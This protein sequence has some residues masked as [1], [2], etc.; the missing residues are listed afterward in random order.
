MFAEHLAHQS[1]D[2]EVECIVG[3]PGNMIK[4]IRSGDHHHNISV[5]YI[6]FNINCPFSIFLPILSKIV[7]FIAS[8][9]CPSFVCWMLMSSLTIIIHN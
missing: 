1:V 2:E 9:K 7:V 5:V 3:V 8:Q 4:K 6:D